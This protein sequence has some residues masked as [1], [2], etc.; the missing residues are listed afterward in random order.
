GCLSGNVITPRTH[1]V[2][3][4][5]CPRDPGDWFHQIIVPCDERDVIVE[6]RVTTEPVCLVEEWS[7]GINRGGANIG[8]ESERVECFDDGDAKVARWLVSPS[9]SIES[10]YFGV[11]NADV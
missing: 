4:K 7:I 8:C 6:V 2:S 5:I 11:V 1:T 3:G 10:W 9:G